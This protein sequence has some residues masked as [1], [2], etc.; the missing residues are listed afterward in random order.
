[1]LCPITNSVSH[2]LRNKCSHPELIYR[3]WN[4]SCHVRF[5]EDDNVRVMGR[6]AVELQDSVACVFV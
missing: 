2:D 6:I 3:E 5:S 1:M 4:Q